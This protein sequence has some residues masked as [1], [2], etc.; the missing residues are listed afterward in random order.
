MTRKESIQLLAMRPGTKSYFFVNQNNYPLTDLKPNWARLDSFFTTNS[1]LPTAN[2]S[3]TNW[4]KNVQ[5]SL[6]LLYTKIKLFYHLVGISDTDY[7]VDGRRCE[8]EFSEDCSCK[9]R[10]TRK[11]HLAIEIIWWPVEDLARIWGRIT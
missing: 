10:T 6:S 1:G 4:E 11:N 3:N 8:M 5:V 7:G 9:K 2:L